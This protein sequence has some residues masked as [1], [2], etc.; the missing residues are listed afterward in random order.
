M[1]DISSDFIL[2][3]F[4][5]IM[6]GSLTT[7]ILGCLQDIHFYCYILIGAWSTWP[8]IEWTGSLMT[9]TQ[10]PRV[11]F[12]YINLQQAGS[13]TTVNRRSHGIL[14]TFWFNVLLAGWLYYDSCLWIILSSLTHC[15]TVT[16][17]TPK[18]ISMHFSNIFIT[19][20]A[21]LQCH[22]FLFNHFNLHLCGNNTYFG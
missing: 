22:N 3:V 5:L 21:H 2:S 15:L 1:N 9:A 6:A 10:E 7:A 11:K 20:H 17:L 18:D 12:N 4:L 14:P 16:Y 13:L 8:P 19:L